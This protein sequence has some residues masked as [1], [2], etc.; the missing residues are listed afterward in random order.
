MFSRDLHKLSLQKKIKLD[1][2]KAFVY[3]KR[4]IDSI[5]GRY[6]MYIS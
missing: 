2:D 1:S 4:R 5:S 6:S 3:F